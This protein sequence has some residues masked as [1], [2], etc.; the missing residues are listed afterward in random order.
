MLRAARFPQ[1]HNLGE[2]PPLQLSGQDDLTQD[3]KGQLGQV[4]GL[5]F[6]AAVQLDP[7]QQVLR[8]E[9]R[10]HVADL[11]EADAQEEPAEIGQGL[12]R[13]IPP[14]IVIVWP[15]AVGGHQK[16][17]VIGDVPGQAA[18]DR[19]QAAPNPEPPEQAMRHQPGH[20]AIAIQER[21]NPEEPV[22]RG[23]RNHF[24]ELAPR[25][26]LRLLKAPEARFQVGA[27]LR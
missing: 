4:A 25:R 5:G 24:S 2:A 11:V 27:C 15:R 10:L 6:V 23:R 13:E 12:F 16:R 21:V 1:V 14:P 9:K 7:P 17:P 22:M 3:S 20:P 19:P 26:A 8:I 18:G